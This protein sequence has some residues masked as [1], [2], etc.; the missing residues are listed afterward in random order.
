MGDFAAIPWSKQGQCCLTPSG[1]FYRY[2]LG[3]KRSVLSNAKW[4]ILQIFPGVNKVSVVY[5][6][7][8]DFA[9]IPLGIKGQCCLIPSGRFCRYSLGYKRSVL[10]NAKWDILQVFPGV[11]KV[12]VI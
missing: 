4:E 6:Q 1:R 10:S 11:N 7:V 3:Y 5:R 9:G 2:I 8:G 12:S